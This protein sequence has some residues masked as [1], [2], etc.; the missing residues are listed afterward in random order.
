MKVELLVKRIEEIMTHYHLTAAAFADSIGVQ[1][2][3]I[4]HLLK[5]RNKPSLEF[6]CKITE[7]YT[8]VDLYWLLYGKGDFPST[9]KASLKTE[10]VESKKS[11]DITPTA[12]EIEKIVTFYNN[13]TFTTHIPKNNNK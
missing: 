8:D 1:R 10:K 6:V 5:G 4:S 2:S 12:S 9:R 7:V 11:A 13:G 3:S